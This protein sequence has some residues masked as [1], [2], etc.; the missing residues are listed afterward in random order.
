MQDKATEI[1]CN[2][3][4][5]FLTYDGKNM[6]WVEDNIVTGSTWGGK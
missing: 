4:L 3:P 2:N 5:V 6:A 1:S